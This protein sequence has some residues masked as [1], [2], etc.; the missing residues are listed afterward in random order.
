MPARSAISSRVAPSCP[1]SRMRA[2][3]ASRS[4][5]RVRSRLSPFVLT[6]SGWRSECFIVL[7]FIINLFYKS[8]TKSVEP[9]FKDTYMKNEERLKKALQKSIDEGQLAGA[10]VL[11]LE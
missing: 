7:D 10:G 11:A 1:F 8:I 9:N 3:A 4:L 5:V 2:R 6:G